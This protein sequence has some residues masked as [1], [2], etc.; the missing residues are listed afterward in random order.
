MNLLSNEKLDW[1]HYTGDERFDYPIDYWGAVLNMRDDGHVDLLYRWEPHCYCHFHRHVCDTT[2][3]VLEG[4]LHITDFDGGRESDTRVR[5]AGDY[6]HKAPGDVH[7][8]KGGPDGALVLFN[9][10][11][12]DGRLA[13]QL[14]PDG[15]VL[16]TTTL[17]DIYTLLQ[18]GRVASA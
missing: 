9:L 2:S 14:A 10:H 13:E 15:S 17:D 3:T 6:A 4:E 12:T 5:R 16:R 11:T 18:R 1:V 7:M 8:E